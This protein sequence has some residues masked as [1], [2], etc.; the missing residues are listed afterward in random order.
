MAKT[1]KA[2]DEVQWQTSQGKTSGTVK[3]KLTSKT[4]IKS[5]VV[6]ASKENPQYL[7]ESKKSGGV[8]AHKPAALKKR[9][10]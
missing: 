10:R 5:H 4:K 8:A 1:L 9:S 2:G 3:K 7:V 6:A